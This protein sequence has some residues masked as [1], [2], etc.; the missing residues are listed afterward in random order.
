MALT[1]AQLRTTLNYSALFVS[2]ALVGI[3]PAVLYLTS[4]GMHK[5]NKAWPQGLYEWYRGPSWDMDTK[6]N[7]RLMYESTNEYTM[8]A[9]GAV[10]AITGLIGIVGF[11][12]GRQVSLRPIL[13][14]SF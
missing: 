1:W 6:H 14:A 9:A 4:H 10:G 8:F 13:Q 2:L 3:S 7:V 11:F 5:M 12:L